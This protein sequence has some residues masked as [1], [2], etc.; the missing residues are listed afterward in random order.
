MTSQATTLKLLILAA[1]SKQAESIFSALQQALLPVRGSFTQHPKKLER[2]RQ[3]DLIIAAISAELSADLTAEYYSK[4]EPAIPLLVIADEQQDPQPLIRLLRAGGGGLLTPGDTAGLVRMVHLHWQTLRLT[5]QNEELRARLKKSERRLRQLLRA[6]DPQLQQEELQKRQQATSEAYRSLFGG[7]DGQPL[8]AEMLDLLAPEYRDAVKSL[9]G[10]GGDAPP[11]APAAASP[12]VGGRVAAPAPQSEPVPDNSPLTLDADSTP[13]LEQEDQ[14][15]FT[16]SQL[17]NQIEHAL[18][19]D[20]LKLVYQPVVSLRGDSQEPYSVL[21]RMLDE[22]REFRPADD[23]LDPAD[24]AGKMP[25]IDHWVI[26][27]ALASLAERRQQGHKAH[28]YVSLSSQTLA[29]SQLLVWICDQ[30]RAYN[31]RGHWISFQL[32]EDSVRSDP[33]AVTGFVD[34][35][36]QIKSRIIISHFGLHPDSELLLQQLAIDLIKLAPRLTLNLGADALKQERVKTLIASAQLHGTRTIAG[37]IE[38]ELSLAT[39][40]TAGADYVQGN[41]IARP[42]PSFELAI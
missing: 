13:Q 3:C 34:G 22:N 10:D 40:W 23:L 7:G 14:A 15:T 20:Q 27:H 37:S 6:A 32:K 25:A 38:D 18:D 24:R 2:V 1:E 30:L 35:L 36:H 8:G 9:L 33:E 12:N 11:A 17:V 19:N 29:D 41:L 5:L 28:L 21:L 42:M 26:E 39:V 31:I 4:L 16:D